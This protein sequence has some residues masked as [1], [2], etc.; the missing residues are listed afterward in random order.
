MRRD[1]TFDL[2]KRSVPK[3]LYPSALVSASVR[4]AS[5]L[6]VLGGPFRGMNYVVRSTWGAYVPKL[7]GTYEL[8]LHPFI[9][10]VLTERP[11]AVIDIGAAEGYYAVGLLMR[12]PHARLTAFEQQAEA[13]SHLERLAETNGVRDRLD[14]RNSCDP[15]NLGESLRASGAQLIVCD[16]EGYEIELLDPER[17]PD[18]RGVDILVEVHDGRVPECGER[19][20]HR[21]S[22]THEVNRIPQRRRSMQ[23]FP[24]S[25]S[26]WRLLPQVILK[27]G[28]SEFRAPTTSWLWLESKELAAR[29]RSAPAS[30]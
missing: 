14:I 15:T 26:P 29:R 3:A 20:A 24:L 21:F 25:R 18:L 30:V 6:H 2:L 11:T 17:V 19:I 8:E 9:E 27:Y 28:L 5:Q 10:R 22:A 13:R 16:V 1:E 7:L 4:K 12:L 23:D